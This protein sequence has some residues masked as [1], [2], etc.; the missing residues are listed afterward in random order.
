MI[1]LRG[2]TTIWRRAYN[3][4]VSSIEVRIIDEDTMEFDNLFKGAR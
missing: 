2:L 1:R 4:P 3:E